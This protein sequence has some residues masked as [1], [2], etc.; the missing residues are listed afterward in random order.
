MLAVWLARLRVVLAVRLGGLA[1]PLLGLASPL[2]ASPLLASSLL[3]SPLAPVVI[4][5]FD[6][7]PSGRFTDFSGA[8]TG[9]AFG[10]G[11]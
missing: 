3:A 5:R 4:R 6:E 10:F 7:K 1:S 9:A 11:G 2:L 8:L